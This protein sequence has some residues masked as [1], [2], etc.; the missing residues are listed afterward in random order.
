[1]E[2]FQGAGAGEADTVSD[3]PSGT[4]STAFSSTFGSQ[5]QNNMQSRC[6]PATSAAPIEEKDC[7][8]PPDDALLAMVQ[9]LEDA[10]DD[11]PGRSDPRNG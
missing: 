2:K 1:M 7:L 10:E 9:E 5:N 4:A 8:E 3:A 6:S 11:F